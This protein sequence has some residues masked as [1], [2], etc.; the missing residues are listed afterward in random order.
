MTFVTWIFEL[1]GLCNLMPRL[2]LGM[3]CPRGSAAPSDHGPPSA[4][5]GRATFH[6]PRSRALLA[7]PF[8]WC[9]GVAEASHASVLMLTAGAASAD[10]TPPIG[11]PMW[12]YAKRHNQ[13]S[14][15]VLDHLQAR[16]LVLD[17]DGERLAIVSL[18]LGRPPTRQSMAR[19]RARLRADAG[20]EHVFIAATHTHHGPVVETNNWPDPGHSYVRE[21]EG[22]IVDVIVKASRAAQ[23]VRVGIGNRDMAANRNRQSKRSDAPVDR[24]LLVIR[25]ESVGGKPIATIVNY[26]AHPTLEDEKVFRFSADYP[27]ALAREVEDA[28]HAPCLFLQGAAGDLSA[29]ASRWPGP[30]RYGLELAKEA[31]RLTEH[32]QCAIMLCPCFQTTEDDFRFS[33]R[34]DFGNPLIRGAFSA[35]FYPELVAF[36]VN[37]YKDG[38]RPHLTTA[39]LNGELGIVGVSGEFFTG[40]S[41]SLKR[42][43]RLPHLLFIGYCN[44][45]QQYFPTIEAAAEGGY[46]ADPQ[47]APA[48]VG[49]GERI[50]DRALIR[51]YQM[52]GKFPS[53]QTV[54]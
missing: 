50:I 7:L 40:H 51:L 26:A 53:S 36:Y 52:Q 49:A 15:G 4:D 13:P 37:E 3:H 19:I 33:S 38:I 41:L 8:L 29:D 27:G 34:I 5:H 21:L 24:E 44:D 28:T 12:G 39:L 18:D 6:V 48:E 16:A 30:S 46:G 35:A 9:T 17:C 45:Y 42:R 47:V 31:L 2:R 25:L 20:I 32:L 22:R 14:E 10:I 1:H 43:S 11:Y 54:P 23:P